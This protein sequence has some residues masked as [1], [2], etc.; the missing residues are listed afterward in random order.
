MR[1]ADRFSRTRMVNSCDV[2]Y[3]RRPGSQTY[4]I[5]KRKYKLGKFF[6]FLLFVKE[7]G[8]QPRTT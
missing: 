2:T 8:D 6:M 7:L 1:Q 4:W 3:W 5:Q